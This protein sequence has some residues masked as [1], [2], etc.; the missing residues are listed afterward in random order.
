MYLKKT[1]T[2]DLC[3]HIRESVINVKL[4]VHM[5][6]G[7]N[8]RTLLTYLLINTMATVDLNSFIN[9]AIASHTDVDTG[10]SE[11]CVDS[12]LVSKLPRCLLRNVY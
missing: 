7:P 4:Y 5:C 10:K 6:T 1:V 8:C 11:Q 12:L 2:V 3:I 9:S